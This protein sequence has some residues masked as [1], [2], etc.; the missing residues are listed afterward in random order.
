M[1][2]VYCSIIEK[3]DPHHEVVWENDSHIAFLT[4]RPEQPGHILVIPKAHTDYVFDL[5]RDEYASLMETCRGLARPLKETL[6]AN[7]LAVVISGFEI[8]HVHVS[9]VPAKNHG[10]L[11]TIQD[12]S[13]REDA[14]V[15]ATMAEKL[16]PA[17]KNIRI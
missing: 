4:I 13:W 16:R 2:C 6:G 3:N 8:P 15:L 14:T 5:P 12:Y 9:L 10:A 17:F 1:I 11:C 7:R